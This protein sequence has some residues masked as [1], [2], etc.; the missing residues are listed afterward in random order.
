MNA[1]TQFYKYFD[2]V[3]PK[4]GKISNDLVLRNYQIDCIQRYFN[5]YKH[6]ESD[7]LKYHSRIIKA[8]PGLGKTY[9]ALVI[10]KIYSLAFDVPIYIV[11]PS[12][13]ISHWITSAIQLN[14]EHKIVITSWG[15]IK[16]HSSL[17]KFIVIVD[18]C[19]YA[20]D[21]KAKRSKAVMGLTANPFNISTI[22][23]SAT[24][25]KNGKPQ[26]LYPLLRMAKHPIAM[27]R[28]DY[29]IQYCGAVWKPF[30]DKNGRWVEV[31]TP[32]KE[33]KNTD[34][35]KKLIKDTFL[36]YNRSECLPD[37]PDKERIL[38]EVTLSK[39]LE[40]DYIKKCKELYDRWLVNPE[41]ADKMVLGLLQQMRCYN[42]LLKA[43]TSLELILEVLES[44]RALIV[45]TCFIS[46]AEYLH[47]E[48]SKNFN[49]GIITGA[50][51]VTD[52]QSVIDQFQ[53]SELDCLVLTMGSCGVG[54]NADRAEYEILIDRGYTAAETLQAED[55]GYRM[56]TDHKI[57]VYWISHGRIDE[58]I[59]TYNK[60]KLK[61]SSDIFDTDESID[62][63]D[64]MKLVGEDL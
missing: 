22:Q 41:N 7:N 13:T 52:R 20:Q 61:Y 36:V 26:N 54:I 43:Q 17:C 45:F 32:G 64:I 35:L 31:L 8:D 33:F 30:V 56:T 27:D 29:Y 58:I 2:A 5:F 10:A 59:D 9:I 60:D 50:T 37:L 3:F 48:I 28:E 19:H 21:Y 40:K 16:Y 38:Y 14:L 39:K 46:S 23:L 6:Q 42:S 57:V 15:S 51:E 1:N 12:S 4:D 63:N 62:Y 47:E 44:K 18:E 53:S 11:T 55:R 24:P 49:C 25:I 34:Q